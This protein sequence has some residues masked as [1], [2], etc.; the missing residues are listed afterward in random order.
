MLLPAPPPG[1]TKS[2][3]IE[4]ILNPPTPNSNSPSPT[5][6][7]NLNTPPDEAKDDGRHSKYLGPAQEAEHAGF[8]ST[9]LAA[10]PSQISQL[11]EIQ[12][13]KVPSGAQVFD[14]VE[15]EQKYEPVLTA[16]ATTIKRDDHVKYHK[17]RRVSIEFYRKLF[18][19]N[20]EGATQLP[21]SSRH[22]HHPNQNQQ[23]NANRARMS[24]HAQNDSTNLLEHQKSYGQFQVASWNEDDFH[25]H[26]PSP[27]T[28]TTNG[29][30][31]VYVFDRN[32]NQLQAASPQ[33]QPPP[34]L[35]QLALATMSSEDDD[36]D[37]D[38]DDDTL[39]TDLL[40]Y[41]EMNFAPM[42]DL[43]PYATPDTRVNLVQLLKSRIYD[44]PDRS[45]VRNRYR[46][47]LYLP[48]LVF[49]AL[50]ALLLVLY[51]YDYH[52][53]GNSIESFTYVLYA[54]PLLQ[55]VLS[56]V[57][58]SQIDIVILSCGGAHIIEECLE[59]QISADDNLYKCIYCCWCN[60]AC[61]QL[62]NCNTCTHDNAYSLFKCHLAL[63]KAL[64][65]VAC[66]LL[67]C[68]FFV[69]SEIEDVNEYLHG[70]KIGAIHHTL[71]T[72]FNDEAVFSLIFLL[73]CAIDLVCLVTATAIG[74]R[75]VRS[76]H[77]LSSL[78]PRTL[79]W[80]YLTSGVIAF[81]MQTQFIVLLLYL[82]L[83]RA[84]FADHELL[85]ATPFYLLLV[86]IEFICVSIWNHFSFRNLD[87]EK[88]GQDSIKKN[89]VQLFD[90]KPQYDEIHDLRNYRSVYGQTFMHAVDD[91][92]DERRR[93]AGEDSEDDADAMP[94]HNPQ[95]SAGNYSFS[96]QKNKKKKITTPLITKSG[97]ITLEETSRPASTRG[98]KKM[99]KQPMFA[100][101]STVT[102]AN[103][104]NATAGVE[105]MD[106][107]DETRVIKLE[108]VIDDDIVNDGQIRSRPQSARQQSSDTHN[109]D[110]SG[111]LTLSQGADN[112]D[113]HHSH[114]QHITTNSISL[115]INMEEYTHENDASSTFNADADAG[116]EKH[117]KT[118]KNDASIA[119]LKDIATTSNT[120]T[121]VP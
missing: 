39:H 112:A 3:G 31:S 74:I 116:S 11:H 101:A 87:F 1:N 14:N 66:P 77:S 16:T 80:Q 7:P 67:T 15:Q 5:P 36:D 118:Q 119:N 30:S 42:R 100:A 44:S 78:T 65:C 93:L 94:M 97:V 68:I 95:V 107:L 109:A 75:I 81:G 120:N 25:A 89:E 37:D 59:V 91:A 53:S 38:Y 121:N 24:Y 21:L 8:P 4:I 12:L 82:N 20:Y 71:H 27:G 64:M 85:A 48:L 22:N 104:E 96:R 76:L 92:A 51:D 32:N 83:T 113:Q 52:H 69:I 50:G 57:L 103:T 45:S 33:A 106:A 72:A 9:S 47:V 34:S 46:C 61:L 2:L 70:T 98:P 54:Y 35:A 10:L 115:E 99:N 105:K 86:Y 6:I 58:C 41:N 62:C 29:A 114:H 23:N 117:A 56:L 90:F 55:V 63:L 111:S 40:S 49:I 17:R 108:S 43:N 19:W 60:C 13:T 84:P 73:V 102:N 110:N 28:A 88:F 18:Y 79:T 26:L